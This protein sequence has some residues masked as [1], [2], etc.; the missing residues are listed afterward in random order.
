M[1]MGCPKTIKVTTK[2]HDVTV[3]W[4]KFKDIDGIVVYY[5]DDNGVYHET[6]LDASKT[7][8]TFKNLESCQN[9]G[10][11]GYKWYK[12]VRVHGTMQA[13]CVELN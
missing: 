2:G 10:V 1:N 9:A 4:S 8:Y 3:K 5:Y 13:K 6:F 7:S 11:C 12:G